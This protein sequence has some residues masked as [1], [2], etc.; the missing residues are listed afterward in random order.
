MTLKKIII[1]FVCFFEVSSDADGRQAFISY[2]H[3]DKSQ[4]IVFVKHLEK[5]GSFTN[6]WVDEKY[7]KDNIVDTITTAILQSKVVFVLLSD[8][9]C[10]SDVCRR[11]WEFALKKHIKVYPIIVQEGFKTHSYDWVDFNISNTLYYKIHSHDELIRLM[12]NLKKDLREQKKPSKMP[13]EPPLEATANNQSDSRGQFKDKAVAKW[14]PGDIRNWC[15]KNNLE[16]WCA[17]LA[18]YHGA[19]LLELNRLLETD[20]NLPHIAHGHGITLIDVVLFKCELQKLL[21]NRK[22]RVRTA[23]KKDTVKH[24]TTNMSTK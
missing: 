9:Y 1:F 20:A 17:P 19:A 21:S 6:I 5:A 4:R 14:T 7:M 15:L 13:T 11:E 22:A 24:R 16:K 8:E 2:C 23:K 3:R 10:S 12:E 18:E